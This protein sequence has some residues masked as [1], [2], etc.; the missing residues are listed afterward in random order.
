MS[1]SLPTSSLLFVLFSH[2]E[3]VYRAAHFT[4]IRLNRVPS[5][6]HP[7]IIHLSSTFNS[8]KYYLTE[9]KE[10]EEEEVNG[11][12]I[13]SLQNISEKMYTSPMKLIKGGK[14]LKRSAPQVF[15]KC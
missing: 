7:P 13:I 4:A 9:F 10:E 8:Y 11:G 2:L 12:A 14:Y 15:H 6:C 5:T 3:S 1:P